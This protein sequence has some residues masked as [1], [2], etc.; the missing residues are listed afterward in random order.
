M[1]HQ[2]IGIDENL[3][4]LP[5]IGTI[6]P[7]FSLEDTAFWTVTVDTYQPFSLSRPTAVPLPTRVGNFL[8]VS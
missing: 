1:L 3:T 8:S 7:F 4:K 2:R 6:R 5:E